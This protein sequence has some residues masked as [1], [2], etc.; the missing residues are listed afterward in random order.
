VNR[1]QRSKKVKVPARISHLKKPEGLSL[2]EWQVILRRQIALETRLRIKNV[3]T[4]PVFST[5]QITNPKTTRT[6]RVV[7]AGEVPGI[8]YCSCPDF[9]VNTLGT[10]KHVEAVLHKLRRKKSHRQTLKEGFQPEY[11]AVTLR[12]GLKRRAVFLLG[13]KA[14]VQLRSLVSEFFDEDFF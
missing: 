2:E 1:K 8:N 5:F 13:A 3:G 6:Y 9:A 14:G 10:C 12:Y 11:S 7:I 4:H